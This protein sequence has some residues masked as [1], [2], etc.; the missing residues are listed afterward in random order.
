ME[1]AIIRESS[2]TKP[3]KVVALYRRKDSKRIKLSLFFDWLICR[4]NLRFTWL[5]SDLLSLASMIGVGCHAQNPKLI[6]HLV[7]TGRM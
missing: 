4:E 3:P 5:I 7:Y 6:T 2:G 1:L